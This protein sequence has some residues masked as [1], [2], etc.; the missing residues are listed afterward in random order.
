MNIDVLIN[1]RLVGMLTHDP[2]LNRFS[3]IYADEWLNREDRFALCPQIPL[4]PFVTESAE[5]HSAAVRRF[6]ENLLPEGQALDD[7]AAAHQVSKSNLAAMLIAVG[8]ETA[9]AIS[10]RTEQP[11][12][13]DQEQLRPLP[14]SEI[15]ER[16]RHRPHRP[17]SVWGWK[18]STFDCRVPGQDCRLPREWRLVPRR[19]S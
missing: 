10:I 9:G 2:Q 14:I 5:T 16:I 11:N 1:G 4:P 7:A 19:R 18:S 15:S 3:F 17:F 12:L 6:F 8:R 13:T